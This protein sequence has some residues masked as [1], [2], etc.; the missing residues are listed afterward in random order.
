MSRIARIVKYFNC[1][2]KEKS[3]ELRDSERDIYLAWCKHNWDRKPNVFL[4]NLIKYF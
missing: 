1:L 4:K 3:I 2:S